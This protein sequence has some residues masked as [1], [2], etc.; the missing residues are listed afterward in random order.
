MTRFDQLLLEA[1]ENN[2]AYEFANLLKSSSC[3]MEPADSSWLFYKACQDECVDIVDLILQDNRFDN[4]IGSSFTLAGLCGVQ[5]W[6]VIPRILQ[7]QRFDSSEFDDMAIA[8]ATIGKN[9]EIVKLLLQRKQIDISQAIYVCRILQKQKFDPNYDHML[10]ILLADCKADFQKIPFVLD[11][12]G[13]IR[14]RCFNVCVGM[15]DLNLPALITLEIL[16]QLIPNDVRMAAKWDLI[17]AVKHFHD[18]VE[19]KQKEKLFVK[20]D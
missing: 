8:N 13:Q 7:D 6:A 18:R 3:K 11:R 19:K 20:N 14:T 15:Q 4:G 12:I 16:D 10:D 9:A 17:V 2:D 1:I 5:K